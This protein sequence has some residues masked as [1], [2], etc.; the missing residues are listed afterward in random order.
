MIQW[1]HFRFGW[2]ATVLTSKPTAGRSA[3][4][5]CDGADARFA[6]RHCHRARH[7]GSAAAVMNNPSVGFIPVAERRSCL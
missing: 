5:S 2:R 1:N 6:A 7:E 4:K 3:D